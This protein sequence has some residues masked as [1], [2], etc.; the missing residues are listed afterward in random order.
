MVLCKALSQAA[1]VQCWVACHMIA[2]LVPDGGEYSK[3]Q[4]L[5]TAGGFAV[6]MPLQLLKSSWLS[7]HTAFHEPQQRFLSLEDVV[8]VACTEGPGLRMLLW[9][10]NDCTL[11]L[12]IANQLY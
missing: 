9:V 2:S 11:P 6:A 12:T 5:G 1:S 4:R 8:L 7:R 3:L 10:V